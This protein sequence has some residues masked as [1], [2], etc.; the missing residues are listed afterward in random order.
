MIKE[1]KRWETDDR[2]TYLTEQEALN[3]ERKKKWMDILRKEMAATSNTGL[4]GMSAYQVC[5]FVEK[6]TKGW[7]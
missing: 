6:Y 5:Q 2:T 3:H 4:Y 1:V 7:K